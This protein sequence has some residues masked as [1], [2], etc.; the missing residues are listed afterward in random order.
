GAGVLSVLDAITIAIADGA[1]IALHETRLVRARIPSVLHP[2][3]IPVGNG[4][5][6]PLGD[7]GLIRAGITAIRDP[8][9]IAIGRRPTG[10]APGGHVPQAGERAPLR[11][12]IAQREPATGACLHREAIGQRIA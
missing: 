1:A 6:I 9:A 5:A 4:A 2:I 10:V 12:A 7:P 8:V 11:C 3:A